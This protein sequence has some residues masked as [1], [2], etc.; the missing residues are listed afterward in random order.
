MFLHKLQAFFFSVVKPLCVD[1]F[2]K[3]QINRFL[4]IYIYL[5]SFWDLLLTIIFKFTLNTFKDIWTSWCCQTK[6]GYK[7]LRP[8]EASKQFYVGKLIIFSH[9]YRDGNVQLFSFILTVLN[10]LFKTKKVFFLSLYQPSFFFFWRRQS[11]TKKLYSLI[12][13]C[14]FVGRSFYQLS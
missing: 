9:I 2:A 6:L 5:H 11:F 1:T 3:Y 4:D 12:K 8:T 13:Q 7:A 10:G 14:P